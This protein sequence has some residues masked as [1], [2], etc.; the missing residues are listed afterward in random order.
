MK[1]K[2]AKKLPEI[3]DINFDEWDEGSALAEAEAFFDSLTEEDY[4][5]LAEIDD[6]ED[7][8]EPFDEEREQAALN[9]LK[10]LPDKTKYNE[11]VFRA[12]SFFFTISEDSILLAHDMSNTFLTPELFKGIFTGPTAEE[13][14]GMKAMMHRIGFNQDFFNDALDVIDEFSA[15]AVESYFNADELADPDGTQI[16][17]EMVQE[18]EGKKTPFQS[19][20]HFFFTLARLGIGN[21]ELCFA[22]D[23]DFYS[24]RNYIRQAGSSPG[25]VPDIPAEDWPIIF[26]ELDSL[27]VTPDPRNW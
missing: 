3:D 19:M 18:I 4:A 11:T 13:E 1:K 6:E 17:N 2:A 16:Y 23:G 12:G 9:E 26:S 25:Y 22:W 8:D 21:K 27:I 15:E 20:E 10:K 7:E 5:A 24:L 14:A